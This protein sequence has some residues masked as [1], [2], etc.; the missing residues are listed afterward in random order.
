MST[1]RFATTRWIS[2][3]QL[4]SSARPWLS[5]SALDDVPLNVVR[6]ASKQPHRVVIN[7]RSFPT[8]SATCSCVSPMCFNEF[9]V[10]VGFL[11]R[12]Q[13]LP[14]DVFDKCQLKQLVVRNFLND[15]RAHAEF[16]HAERRANGVSPATIWITSA[17]LTLTTIG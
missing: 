6:Q 10:C 13:L 12:I 5:E 1:A 16:L 15:R 2:G 3:R 17:K 4:I 7:V 11:D 14:L 8:R 9:A